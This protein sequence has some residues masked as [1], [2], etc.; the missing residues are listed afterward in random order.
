MHIGL[1]SFLILDLSKPAAFCLQGKY[2]TTILID[3]VKIYHYLNFTFKFG[4]L[5]VDDFAFVSHRSHNYSQHYKSDFL[6]A[7]KLL[8]F[9]DNLPN[10]INIKI[11]LY[12]KEVPC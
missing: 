8:L 5:F 12:D 9:A 1:V 2:I 4:I 11:T 6:S 3:I 7:T 10:S